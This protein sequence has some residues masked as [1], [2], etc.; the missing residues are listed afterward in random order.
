[1]FSYELF[2][3]AIIVTTIINPMTVFSIRSW[4]FDQLLS[5]V[6]FTA[7][8]WLSSCLVWLSSSSFIFLSPR[9]LLFPEIALRWMAVERLLARA[10]WPFLCLSVFIRFTNGLVSCLIVS[11]TATFVILSAQ[12]CCGW[13][14]SI[15]LLMLL[16]F[17]A[18]SLRISPIL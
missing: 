7:S 16:F 9:H 4:A 17:T 13:F 10:T 18:V 14:Y 2:K 5:H 12:T 15:N 3:W 8:I 11:C 6:R 1:M